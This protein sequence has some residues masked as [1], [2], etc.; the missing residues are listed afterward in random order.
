MLKLLNARALSRTLTDGIQLRAARS[1]IPGPAESLL[2]PVVQHHTMFTATAGLAGFPAGETH[3][4]SG[5]V[6][7]EVT[8]PSQ[9]R[10]TQ[11]NSEESGQVQ[12]LGLGG[13]HSGVLLFLRVQYGQ[14]LVHSVAV[15]RRLEP[16]ALRIVCRLCETSLRMH[17]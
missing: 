16:V 4:R 1:V 17:G 7:H 12:F 8:R 3:P 15:L 10:G 13:F 2:G 9:I 5:V 6:P 11:P 14:L